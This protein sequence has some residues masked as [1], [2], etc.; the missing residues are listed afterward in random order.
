M[1]VNK[2]QK[3]KTDIQV[4]LRKVQEQSFFMH[5]DIVSTKHKISGSKLGFELDFKLIF[6]EAPKNILKILVAAIYNY[7]L[8]MTEKTRQVI[9]EISTINS[10]EIKDMSSHISVNPDDKE[11]I[12]DQA[13]IIPLLLEIAAN[14]I[15]GVMVAKTKDTA[16]IDFPLPLVNMRDLSKRKNDSR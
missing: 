8:E 13:G 6:D 10:F 11:K 7:P 3:K 16:L 14:T 1:V 15:R 12:T 5:P 9:L 4:F 2:E